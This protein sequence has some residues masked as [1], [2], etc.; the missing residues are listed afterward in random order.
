[1]SL[2]EIQNQSRIKNNYNT[3]Q[4]STNTNQSTQFKNE[5][6]KAEEV[7]T[8]TKID[9][10]EIALSEYKSTSRFDLNLEQDN[11][12]VSDDITV[13]AMKAKIELMLKEQTEK[14]SQPNQIVDAAQETGLKV[15]DIYNIL[16]TNLV[17][18]TSDITAPSTE[19]TNPL[20]QVSEGE[21]VVSFIDDLSGNEVFVT[22]TNDNRAS[23]EKRFGDINSDESKEFV[24]SWYNEAAYQVGYLQSDVDQDGR[25]SM[26][27]AKELNMMLVVD[28]NGNLQDSTNLNEM[29]SGNTKKIDNF[30]LQHGYVDNI[31]EFINISISDDKNFDNKLSFKEVAKEQSYDFIKTMNKKDATEVDDESLLSQIDPTI[32]IAKLKSTNYHLANEILELASEEI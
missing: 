23:I 4:N 3:N 28:N 7:L 15:A 8:K 11:T 12:Q 31:N 22:L 13:T 27:E 20:E 30:I 16:N 10:K 17:D 14:K 19:Y 18:A 21:N 5:L 24:K 29:F 25:I 9:N 2:F 26:A 1:M 6:T 32:N